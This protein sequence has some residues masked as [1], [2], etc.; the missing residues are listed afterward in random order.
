MSKHRT[1][2]GASLWVVFIVFLLFTAYAWYG[3]A[4]TKCDGVEFCGADFVHAFYTAAAYAMT[5]AS[6]VLLIC[7]SIQF[8]RR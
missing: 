4:M 3:Q 8:V 2:P 1:A 5:A 7:I 6:V